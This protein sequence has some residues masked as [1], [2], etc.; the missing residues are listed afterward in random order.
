MIRTSCPKKYPRN[1]LTSSEVSHNTREIFPAI[2]LGECKTILQSTKLF[3]YLSFYCFLWL[4]EGTSVS[5]YL[6]R[7]VSLEA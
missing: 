6:T 4:F 1:P 3:I 7:F 5:S 2:Y